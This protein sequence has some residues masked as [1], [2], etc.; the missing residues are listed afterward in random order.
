MDRQRMAWTVLIGALCAICLSL[1]C[2]VVPGVPAM[3]P[4]MAGIALFC[5]A[6]IACRASGQPKLGTMI[7]CLII[8]GDCLWA[9]CTAL[10]GISSASIGVLSVASICCLTIVMSTKEELLTAKAAAEAKALAEAEAAEAEA[11]A[12]AE[13]TE[14]LVAARDQ[15]E[16]K[17]ENLLCELLRTKVDVTSIN[18]WDNS[19]DGMDVH[20]DLP[21]GVTARDLA[22]HVDKIASA[23]SLHLPKGCIVTVREGDYQCEV[24]LSVM[25]R[26]CLTDHVILEPD[27]A[28]SSIND[29]FDFVRTPQGVWERV[30]LRIE[31][32]IV[33]GAPGSG[34]T[35]LLHRIIAYLAACPDALIWIVDLN[36][37]GLGAVW[38]RLYEAGLTI[39][40]TVDWIGDNTCEAAVL[41]ACAHEVATARKTDVDIIKLKD[42]HKTNVLPVSALKPAIVVIID[43]GGEVR[44]AMDVLGQIVCGRISRLAQI[45]R[46]QAVRVI[47]SVL[48]GTSGMLDKSLR[49]MCGTRICLRMNEE[50]EADH[51]LGR[52]P[53]RQA[54][55]HTGSAWLYRAGEDTECLITRTVD[56]TPALIERVSRETALSRP[57]LDKAAQAVCKNITLN[58]VF[59]GKDPK[60]Y[61]DECETPPLQDVT[62]GLAYEGRWERRKARLDARAKGLDVETAA[63]D[64]TGLIA[65][66]KTKASTQGTSGSTRVASWCASVDKLGPAPVGKTHGPEKTNDL[67]DEF[68]ALTGD[69][70]FRREGE[71]PMDRGRETTSVRPV[72]E[73]GEDVPPASNLTLREHIVIIL[74]DEMPDGL[75]SGQIKA[76]LDERG[77]KY[78]DANLYVQLSAMV[79]THGQ[80][81]KHGQTYTRNNL[82]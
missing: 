79:N 24:V 52:N 67:V 49:T 17:I 64:R 81:E 11:R 9:S 18:E 31:S 27:Q 36:G 38:T 39:K 61:P 56:V 74:E 25:L 45:G 60:S 76:R 26:D 53:G 30:C 28:P 40:P 4:V 73:G 14:N 66:T 3:A 68:D 50:G 1:T 37:G 42:I 12:I 8:V 70:H 20:V 34:K 47:A 62:L 75:T 63:P 72:R 65:R 78:S 2:E 19:G 55:R 82:S 41:L 32:M 7:I 44:Q 51:V 48:R 43:E 33:G 80:A 23:K 22:G 54:L 5:S 59:S 58:H 69:D 13:L 57:T 15:R 71:N 21:T 10:I 6:L 46:E 29:A 77:I 16:I 35:T